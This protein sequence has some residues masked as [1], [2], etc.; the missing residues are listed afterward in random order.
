MIF[1]GWWVAIAAGFIHLYANGAVGL[2]FTAIFEPISR[3]FGWS[4]TQVSFA[5]SIRGMELGILAP[6]LG[7]VVDRWGPRRLLFAGT[8]TIGLGLLVLSQTTSLGMFYGAYV[9]MAIGTSCCSGTIVLTAVNHWFHKKL[10]IA[11][12]IVS[13]GG[14]LGGF[15]V[16]IIVSLID[17]YDWR[18]AVTIL[19]ISILALG[20]PLSLV[21]RHKPEQYGYQLDGA[22]DDAVTKDKVNDSEQA[23]EVNISPRQAVKTSAFWHIAVALACLMMMVNAVTTHVIPYLSSIGVARITASWLASAIPIV[24]IGGRLGFGFLADRFGNRWVTAGGFIIV[25]ISFLLFAYAGTG[26]MW[27]L[28]P[29]AILF[30]TGWGGITVLRVSI[31]REHFGRANFG[32]IHGFTVGIVMLGQ[33]SGPLIAGWVFDTWGKYQ[34]IWLAFVGLAIVALYI[35]VTTPPAR[36]TLT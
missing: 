31:L 12:G 25:S 14:G 24:S 3:E 16:P 19:A 1:Y 10:G 15:L 17:K 22:V 28:V 9:L 20:L 35:V 29:F 21:V 5:A 26:G 33:L 7:L 34:G 6:L 2:G 23:T 27:L 8:A 4:Y 30:G 13:A 11:V 18:M 32:T 36:K